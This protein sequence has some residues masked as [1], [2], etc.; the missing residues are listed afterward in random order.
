MKL[1]FLNALFVFFFGVQLILFAHDDAFHI[2]RNEWEKGYTMIVLEST[3]IASTHAA[4]EYVESLGG[5]IAIVIPPRIM[6]GWIPENLRTT[7]QG[8]HGIS[9]VTDQQVNLNSFASQG[10]DMRL[11][12]NIFNYVVSGA[13]QEDR[14]K[15]EVI[16][17]EPISGDA[18]QWDSFDLAGK[19]LTFLSG[20]SDSMTGTVSVALFLVESNGAIDPNSYTWTP[21]DEITAV[22]Q[23]VSGLNWWSAQ[24]PTYSS[25]VTFYLHL[26]SSTNPISQQPYEP[27]LHSSMQSSLWVNAITTNLGYSSLESFN[28]NLRSIYGT[29]WAY[30]AFIGYN[31][32]PAPFYFTDNKY[33]F[34]FFGGPYTQLLFQGIGYDGSTMTHETGHIFWACDEYYAPGYGGCTSCGACNPNGPRPTAQNGNCEFCNTAAVSCVMRNSRHTLCDHTPQQIGWGTLVETE[35]PNAVPRNDSITGSTPNS[36]WK[37]YFVDVDFFQALSVELYNLTADAD[38]YVAFDRKPTLFDSDCSSSRSGTTVERC[39]LSAPQVGRYWIGI[40]NFSTGTINYTI[41]ATMKQ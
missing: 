18:R 23:V 14:K 9:F 38:L 12:A 15:E 17:R 8:Q 41:A 32:P 20:N 6:F 26:Y 25:N 3:D 11:A 24:A 36:T 29:N 1:K 39:I 22:N 19:S 37:Y 33:A 4:Q 40:N 30:S 31:P 16:Q 7:I 2:E 5:K 10:E 21:A 34:A 28:S 27:I 35:L 13:V